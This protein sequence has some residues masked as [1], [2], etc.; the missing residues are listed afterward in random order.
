M[1]FEYQDNHD[2][3]KMNWAMFFLCI[4]CEIRSRPHTAKL[5]ICEKQLKKSEKKLKK[6]LG[7]SVVVYIINPSTLEAETGRSLVYRVSSRTIKLRQQRKPS[8]PESW[9]GMGINAENHSQILHGESK[10]EFST[11][12]IHSE[13]R[14]LS[15]R[16][17]G[18]TKSQ[19]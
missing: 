3:I 13:L 11:K 15:G 19:R 1:W 7:I 6:S 17:S 9:C 14:E 16:G 5:P 10:L 12:S 18:K 2:L 4:F 8:R